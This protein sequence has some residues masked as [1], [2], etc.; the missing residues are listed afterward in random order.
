[1]TNFLAHGG[2]FRAMIQ[3]GSHA[4]ADGKD[5][6]GLTKSQAQR[7]LYATNPLTGR[8]YFGSSTQDRRRFA[9]VEQ[10]QQRRLS[11]IRQ[12]ATGYPDPSRLDNA[13]HDRT[14]VGLHA[15]NPPSGGAAPTGDDP[16]DASEGSSTPN[17]LPDQH[18]GAAKQA[19]AGAGGSRKTRRPTATTQVT[20]TPPPRRAPTTPL[21]LRTGA[22]R[23]LPRRA[24]R[25]S[26]SNWP[27]QSAS[28][29]I[30]SA[31]P[32]CRGGRSMRPCART[33]WTWPQPCSTCLFSLTSLQWPTQNVKRSP[34]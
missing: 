13:Q 16:A 33:R 21:G 5:Q 2:R 3:D 17:C 10:S 24:P 27:W 20:A 32:C 4:N 18:T 9:S 30:S 19:A 34:P 31:K 14:G 7:G 29:T 12:V 1:M 8:D 25:R 23:A 22:G 15:G 26:G 11:D 28:G 6:Q